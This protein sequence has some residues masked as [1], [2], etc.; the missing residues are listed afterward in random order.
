M[1]NLTHL[2]ERGAA[3]MVNVGEKP[4]QRRRAIATG[5]LLCAPATLEILRDG[6]V[7]KGDAFATARI[8]GIL[9]AKR[10]DELIPL[11]HGL[12]LNAV[13]VDFE[14][15]PEGVVIRAEASVDARTGIEME[16]LTA[17]SVAALTLYD[18]L[19]AVDK[20]MVITGIRVE[21]KEKS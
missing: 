17:V 13:S 3:R 6:R 7:P 12:P 8:A 18:M 5:K 21:L 1:N 4:V 11:C 15:T 9:A 19:K 20:G 14:Y 2:D 16:A 10:T